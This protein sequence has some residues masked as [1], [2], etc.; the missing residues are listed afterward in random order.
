[1]DAPSLAGAVISKLG[2]AVGT[3]LFTY[4]W[5]QVAS[6][7]S[8]QKRISQTVSMQLA[9]E[10]V[11][12]D[13]RRQFEMIGEQLSQ[14]L[15]SLVWN[16]RNAVAEADR[17]AIV[18]FAAN[19]IAS[20]TLT[21]KLVHEIH[22]NVDLLTARILEVNAASMPELDAE[23]RS[24]LEAVLYQICRSI[25]FVI[26]DTPDFRAAITSQ[27]LS[28]LDE[29]SAQ[30]RSLMTQ[31]Q[32]LFHLAE[33]TLAEVR[34]YEISGRETN[35]NHQ[36]VQFET[37]YRFIVGRVLDQV[38]LYGVD[39]PDEVSR[40]QPLSVAYVSMRTIAERLQDERS[41]AVTKQLEPSPIRPG[42][43]AQ[44]IER[45]LARS[46]RLL[47][48]GNA[49][50]GKTTFLQWLAVRS[51]SRSFEGALAGLNSVIPFFIRLRRH[52]EQP[53]PRPHEFPGLISAAIP[54]T[55][56]AGW[57]TDQLTAGRAL[58]LV[59]GVDEVSQSRRRE[60]RDWLRDLVISFGDST[61]VVTSRGQAVAEDWLADLDFDHAELLPLDPSTIPLF[62]D[63][64]HAAVKL[65]LGADH[66]E[67]LVALAE[68]L[69]GEI[70]RTPPLRELATSPL[71]CALI[72]ALNRSRV[73]NVPTN[74]LEIY[75]ACCKMLLDRMDPERGVDLRDFPSLG[76][77]R[78]V[79]IF[80]DFAYWLLRNGMTG[81]TVERADEAFGRSL[82]ALQGLPSDVTPMAVREFF[83][84]RS[85]LVQEPTVGVLEFV[86]RTFQEYLAARAALRSD[87]VGLLVQS[88]DNDQWRETIVLAAG[89]ADPRQFR[90]LVGALIRRGDAV[91]PLRHKM[92]L[93]AA[94]CRD[95]SIHRDDE[96]TESIEDRVAALVPPTSFEEADA[97]AAAGDL[98]VPYLH[99]PSEDERVA[100]ASVRALAGVGS[101]A[102]FDAVVEYATD[103]RVA[104]RDQIIAAWRRFDPELFGTK[105]LPLIGGGD[106]LQLPHALSLSGV[107]QLHNL[108]SL[109]VFDCAAISDLTPLRSLVSLK[110]LHLFD[111]IR[112]VDL[113]PLQSLTSLEALS[114][115]GAR[116]LDDLAPIGNHDRLSYLCLANTNVTDDCIV[117]VAGLRNLMALELNR[118][119]ISDASLR[120][121]ESLTSLKI[122]DLEYASITDD[123]LESCE[124]PGTLT[125][126][127]LSGPQVSGRGISFLNGCINLTSLRLAQVED[128]DS[129]LSK[130]A[131]LEKLA[132]ITLI[133]TDI[134][135]KGLSYLS[136]FPRLL[137][138]TISGGRFSG[139]GISSLGR[140]P[141]ISNLSLEEVSLT[142]RDLS[143]LQSLAGLRELSLRSSPVGNE[144]AQH[145][146]LLSS[147]DSLDLE[148]TDVTDVGL[149]HLS[150]LRNLSRINVSNSRVTRSG[151]QKFR[152][153]LPNCEISAYGLR[154]PVP[155]A[156][157]AK[158]RILAA[159]RISARHDSA[160]DS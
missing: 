17:V 145:L 47:V 78:T 100:A 122:L 132:S 80:E 131:A 50:S 84:L 22:L 92:H 74:R 37:A 13:A 118:T 39:L 19:A 108:K 41:R 16:E 147:L 71:L 5:E 90:E 55:A 87:E 45:V 14:D 111:G 107:E 160:T 25:I 63:Q 110:Q 67:E 96:L 116:S 141:A 154:P 148:G 120:F 35:A 34:R 129:G 137:S 44:P 105:I 101:D 58:V 95:I 54:D 26:Q 9:G 8:T 151:V 123:G 143:H 57:V 130:L 15:L 106:S 6:T 77:E 113:N 82:A 38:E 133:Q 159:L 69:K 59:D 93:L 18:D 115:A 152:R 102:A 126:L 119:A 156:R 157:R 64:W 1:M 66:H 142:D 49:G 51:A 125:D 79:H 11:R 83:R 134:G 30:G 112:I 85:G 65:R 139:A 150:N 12:S 3:R 109:T 97:L 68:H 155:M 104:V 88:A 23:G 29:L 43:T 121:L 138:L 70:R 136:K 61:F 10:M 53:L 98:A 2:A 28:Q 36:G 72:C 144:A 99:G 48:R 149:M 52:I 4:I 27:L 32:S 81:V 158:E 21:P 31:N 60:V 146:A 94:A 128:M 56:P 20:F 89:R 73:R 91:K 124:L 33:Q 117:H 127:R 103:S 153:I 114:L 42:A 86:H 46:R 24:L 62:I 75:D 7:P 40:R 76:Y 135:D 140:L